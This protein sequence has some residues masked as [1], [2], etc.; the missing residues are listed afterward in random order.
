MKLK[1]LECILGSCRHTPASKSCLY[2]AKVVDAENPALEQ[3][4][5]IK[6]IIKD[7]VKEQIDAIHKGTSKKL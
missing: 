2:W 3:T 1:D 5:L 4:K 6:K 7:V